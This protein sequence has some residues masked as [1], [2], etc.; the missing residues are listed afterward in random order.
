MLVGA[1]SKRCGRAVWRER[2]LWKLRGMRHFHRYGMQKWRRCGGCLSYESP[3]EK[4]FWRE[5]HIRSIFYG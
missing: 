5:Y 3:K 4:A 2:I 1:E